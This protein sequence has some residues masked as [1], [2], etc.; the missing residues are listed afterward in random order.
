MNVKRIF[1]LSGFLA[2]LFWG[3]DTSF[4][5]LWVERWAI[6]L[7]VVCLG[8][9]WEQ[10]W[11][12][13]L[14]PLALTYFVLS[15]TVAAHSSLYWSGVGN[16]AAEMFSRQALD[17]LIYGLCFLL[18]CHGVFRFHLWFVGLVQAL[19]I[20]WAALMGHAHLQVLG[21]SN[22]SMAATF[23]V[24]ALAG[25]GNLPSYCVAL[26]A[27]LCTGALMP[28][29]TLCAMS[30]CLLPRRPALLA[31]LGGAALLGGYLYGTP[32]LEPLLNGRGELWSLMWGFFREQA[33][34]HWVLGLGAG[35][36]STWLPLLQMQAGQDPTLVPMA[37]WA[38]NDWLS[39]GFEYGAVGLLLAGACGYSLLRHAKT[40]RVRA[41]LLGAC[42]AM[43]GNFPLHWPVTAVLIWF[44]IGE[45]ALD[46]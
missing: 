39:I 15:A 31:G 2:L 9:T 25:Q 13:P 7:G 8:Y 46:V 44:A 12:S 18:I 22:P 29:L 1:I 33:P 16:A 17:V 10:E 4:H 36:T 26:A 11:R 42:V 3:L 30:L 35:S 43:L 14:F 40:R 24:L 34:W 45:A 37:F 38:H 32:H 27:A 6:V 23:V 19:C 21:L 20:F 5:S 28:L 41:I